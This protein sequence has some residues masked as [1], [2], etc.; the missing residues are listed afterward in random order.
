MEVLDYLVIGAGQQ[1]LAF[2][3]LVKDRGASVLILEAREAPGARWKEHYDSLVLFTPRRYSALPGLLLPGAPH[4]Y[5]TKNEFAEYLQTYARTFSLPVRTHTPV[6]A[7]T[8]DDAHFVARTKDAVYTARQVVVAT[9]YGTPYIPAYAHTFEKHVVSLH[10]SS[11]KNEMQ[12]PAGPLLVVGNGN[13]ASQIAVELARSRNVDIALLETPKVIAPTYLGISFY[14]WMNLFGFSRVSSQSF[15]G[16]LLAREKDYVVGDA[17]LKALRS[18]HIHA[19]PGVAGTRDARILFADGSEKEYG[20]VIWATG[21]SQNLGWI[22]I[23]GALDERG[24]PHE[25]CGMSPIPGLAYLGLRN[26]FTPQSSNI[27]GVGDSARRVLAAFAAAPGTI[28]AA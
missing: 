6:L 23:P 10:S 15:L 18:G 26:Q 19:Q 11:Y 12:L 5:P 2:G 8:K 25:H 4:G 28:G 21:F 22:H 14:F 24:A 7:L 16:R 9:G 13:S 20:G 17:L 3:K 27:V 1:G